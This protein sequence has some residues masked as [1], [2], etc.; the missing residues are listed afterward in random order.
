M[1]PKLPPSLV[2]PYSLM[3]VIKANA[4]FIFSSAVTKVGAVMRAVAWE[5]ERQRKRNCGE[6]L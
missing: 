3:P 5:D 1:K 4:K 6:I 2:E